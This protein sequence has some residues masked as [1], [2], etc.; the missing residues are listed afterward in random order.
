[1]A[2]RD[3]REIDALKVVHDEQSRAFETLECQFELQQTTRD[4]C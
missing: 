1:M 3:R 4:A 2:L